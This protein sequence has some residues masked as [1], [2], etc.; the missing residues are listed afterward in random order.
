[1]SF[2]RDALGRIVA[3]TT[4]G[5]TIASRD[6]VRGRRAHRRTPSGA[7]SVWEYD[8][9][10]NPVTLRT[11]GRTMRFG[12]D[13]LGREV[14]RSLDS[15]LTLAQAWTPKNRLL[16]Q[17]ITGAAGHQVQ[18]RS[19]S[20]QEDG[21]LAAVHDRLTGP[22]TFGLDQVGRVTAVQG[23]G[24]TEQYAYDAAGNVAQATWATPATS[25][26]QEAPGD[27]EYAGNLLR[28]AGNFHYQYDAQGRIVLRQRQRLSHKP[29]TWR[30]SWNAEDRLVGVVTPDGSRWRYRYD[31]FGRRIA[32]QR[33][34]PDGRNVIEQ[35]DFVWD[36]LVL[37]ERAQVGEPGRGGARVTVWN[38]E[39]DG[40]R[41]LLQS[42]R[43]PLRDAPQQWV[44][45][46]F[47]VIVTALA[48]APTELV[49]DDGEIAWFHRHTLWGSTLDQSR[50]G[51]ETPLRFPGQYYDRETGL[52]YNFFRY[53]D[54]ATGRYAS[55]DPLGLEA[56]PNN[57]A[58]VANPHLLTDP[59][60]LMACDELNAKNREKINEGGWDLIGHHGTG[61]QNSESILSGIN[62]PKAGSNAGTNLGDGFYVTPDK[63][64]ANEFA[65]TSA[66]GDAPE[67]TGSFKQWQ[68]DT[69]A[70][71]AKV[72]AGKDHQVFD[73]YAKRDSGGNKLDIAEA[74][75]KR[76]REDPAYK[77]KMMNDHDALTDKNEKGSGLNETKVNP[78]AY[79]RLTAV[80]NEDPK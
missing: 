39:P 9:N 57:Y 26:N 5:R 20:Y 7:E 49:T 66:Y 4:N 27:R 31:P 37:A 70:Y 25:E 74:D 76:M 30:Y 60:G 41:P 43:F 59:L 3:E 16:S 54:P 35:V 72:A 69:A 48:G 10:D 44:D 51:A 22:R 17:T 73:I 45:E 63:K 34:A 47:Y 67:M 56:G 62:P 33:L 68:A 65:E 78:K 6:D 36:G 50:T 14:Q 13:G 2:Q 77:E 53:Y 71:D 75:P 32:K 11:A 21:V 12:Y 61:K 42:E 8:H 29:D 15:G 58:Y 55:A 38:H 52:H 64:T 1:M 79:D 80:F 46:Q 19:Y 40:Y 28:R 24:L 23:S 18:Q